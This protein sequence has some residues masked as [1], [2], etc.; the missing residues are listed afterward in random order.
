MLKSFLMADRG[1]GVLAG[2]PGRSEVD[3]RTVVGMYEIG[4]ELLN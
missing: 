1:H 2:A 4:L 3:Y